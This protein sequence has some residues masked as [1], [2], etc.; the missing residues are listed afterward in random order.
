MNTDYLEINRRSWNWKTGQ[1]IVSRFYDVDGFLAGKNSL[2]EIETNILGDVRGKSILHLQCHFGQ[3]SLS[4]ARLGAKVVGIDLSD[5]AIEKAQELNKTL[6][7]DAEFICSDV[8]DLPNRLDRKFDIV[9]TS[10]GVLGWL[11]DL[12]RWAGVIGRFTKPSGMFVLVE[13][14]PVVW[15]FDP[16]FTKIDYPYSSQEPIIEETGTYTDMQEEAAIPTVNWNHGIGDVVTALIR[17][18]IAVEELVEYD[19]SPY[20]IFHGAVE[21]E[22]GRFH[23]FDG[24]MPLVY[25]LVGRPKNDET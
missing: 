6:G 11:P 14:H 4:L 5:A 25:S 13:F 22:P 19:Y 24:K 23:L 16:D 10:Y 17:Q 9:F 15:M 8:Y 21:S 7:L 1:H 20:D 18:K 12:E 3:D 2:N